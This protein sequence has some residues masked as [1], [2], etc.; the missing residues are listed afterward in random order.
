MHLKC[1]LNFGKYIY[2]HPKTS[3]TA[4]RKRGNGGR[5]RESLMYQCENW[6]TDVR[7]KHRS[8][9]SYVHPNRG[10]K[11]QPRYILWTGIEPM[12]FCC[13]GQCSNQLGHTGQSWHI[14]FKKFSAYSPNVKHCLIFNTAVE[15]ITVTLWPCWVILLSRMCPLRCPRQCCLDFQN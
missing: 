2:P 9:V 14:F 10:S 4:F 12:I 15:M 3:I 8:V 5:E 1:I 13:M 11:P 7:E 6:C